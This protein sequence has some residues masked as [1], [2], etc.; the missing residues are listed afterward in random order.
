MILH[1]RVIEL[2]SRKGLPEIQENRHWYLKIPVCTKVLQ[3]NIEE[4]FIFIIC[5]CSNYTR[6][7]VRY[8]HSVAPHF[9]RVIGKLVNFQSTD[10]APLQSRIFSTRENGLLSL[11]NWPIGH[12]RHN[13]LLGFFIPLPTC[14]ANFLALLC[15]FGFTGS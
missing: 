2:S 15:F 11:F 6:A 10:F 14:L 4:L 9:R 5:N 13:A 7:E 8:K 12:K 3:C 1:S